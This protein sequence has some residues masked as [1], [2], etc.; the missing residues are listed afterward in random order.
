MHSLLLR[1]GGATE[2]RLAWQKALAANPPD[3]NAWF[4]Y[5]ELCLFL[6]EAEEYR[7]AR[8]DLLAR[9]GASTDQYV[10][11]RTGR[12]CLLLPASDDE[13]RQAEALDRPR[14]SRS[15]VYQELGASPLRHV[16]QGSG[17]V[18]PGPS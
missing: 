16:R 6:G 17:G 3:H 10:A 14:R 8:R 5:A 18:S 13:M 15:G 4:G 7:R 12:A 2:L 1:V 9:F 11:E